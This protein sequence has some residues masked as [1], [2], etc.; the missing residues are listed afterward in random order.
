MTTTAEIVP[1]LSI[2]GSS[3][4]RLGR[5]A[6]V[7]LSLG[8][9]EVYCDEVK[10]WKA[11]SRRAFIKSCLKILEP[12]IKKEEDEKTSEKIDKWLRVQNTNPCEL[13]ELEWTP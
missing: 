8:D 12:N 3:C 5:K 11:K 10:L 6:A 7:V 9:K 2:F 4:T 1:I 13:G